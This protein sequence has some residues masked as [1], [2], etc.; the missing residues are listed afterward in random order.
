MIRFSF[1]LFRLTTVAVADNQV[2]EV[3]AR[4]GVKLNRGSCIFKINLVKRLD[5]NLVLNT[6]RNERLVY[7]YKHKPV[8]RKIIGYTESL[9]VFRNKAPSTPKNLLY[10]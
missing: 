3:K 1:R 5:Q 4:R 2:C 9:G 10:I 8:H 6:Q 7:E